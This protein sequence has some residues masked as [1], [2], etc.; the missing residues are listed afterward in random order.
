M[1][2]NSHGDFWD[3]S[4]SDVRDFWTASLR[5]VPTF[6]YSTW[7]LIFGDFSIS[8]VPTRLLVRKTGCIVPGAVN[9]T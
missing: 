6:K 9:G 1:P 5:I 3:L 8:L 2:E 4:E 7:V